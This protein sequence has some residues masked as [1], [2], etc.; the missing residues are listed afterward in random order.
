M[1]QRFEIH[2]VVARNKCIHAVNCFLVKKSALFNRVF[3]VVELVVSGT[4]CT[5]HPIATQ[6]HTP[7]CIH[8]GFS[9]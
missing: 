3:V 9:P 4:Q 1:I 6:E 2:L 7:G 5:Q 8:R